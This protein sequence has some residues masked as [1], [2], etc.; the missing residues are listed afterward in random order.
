MSLKN[1]ASSVVYW[2]SMQL[3]GAQAIGFGVINEIIGEKDIL[4]IEDN[5]ESLGAEHK[6][7]QTSAFGIVGKYSTFFS[8]HMSTKEGGL[9]ATDDKE[10]YNMLISLRAHGWT[11]HLPKENLVSNKSD[12]WFEESFSF[13]LPNYNVRPGVLHGALGVEQLKK[14]DRLIDQRRKNAAFF[15]KTFAEFDFIQTQREIGESSWFGFSMI[16]KE[17]CPFTRAQLIQAFEQNQVECRP[18]VSGNFVK[19]EVLKYFDYRVVGTLKN[20]EK[21]DT[22]GLFLG[23][24]HYDISDQIN[25]AAQVIKN[26]IIQTESK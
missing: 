26:L 23:N 5:C 2:S 13:L 9:V 24:H 3:F 15:K 12:N 20:A 22:S 11:R 14:L 21:V 4:L 1:Q 18:I 19:N 7:K 17:N 10:I 16:L 6:G 25:H 8:H